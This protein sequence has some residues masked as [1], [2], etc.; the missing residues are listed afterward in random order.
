[1]APAVKI[2]STSI[3]NGFR[4]ISEIKKKISDH[5]ENGGKLADLSEIKF[6]DPKDL[7]PASF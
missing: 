5:I 6:V 1:M 7:F 4:G 3:Q 2:D